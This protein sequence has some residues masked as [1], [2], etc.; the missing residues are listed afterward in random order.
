MFLN[1]A[2]LVTLSFGSSELI[3]RGMSIP[4][5]DT[6]VSVMSCVVIVALPLGGYVADHYRAPNPVMVG[7]SSPASCWVRTL[8]SRRLRS[9]RL[10]CSE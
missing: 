3:G 1:G 9:S 2:N 10:P 6:V 7:D 4:A 5:A 8:R